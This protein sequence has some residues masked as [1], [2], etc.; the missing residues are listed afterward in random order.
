[1]SVEMFNSAKT[2]L[3][4]W[5]EFEVYNVTRLIK[6]YRDNKLTIIG[7]YD[8]ENRVFEHVYIAINFQEEGTINPP[9][10]YYLPLGLAD[11][12]NQTL[13]FSAYRLAETEMLAEE[14]WRPGRWELYLQQLVIQVKEVEQKLATLNQKPIDDRKLFPEFNTPL[15]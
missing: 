1:M 5:G 12:Q 4:T 14:Y 8:R 11:N 15:Q 2:I 7:A 6:I 10:L 3:A 9:R 13:V